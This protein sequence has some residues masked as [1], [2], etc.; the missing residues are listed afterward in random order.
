M[1]I[2]YWNPKSWPLYVV[3]EKF[4]F[5]KASWKCRAPIWQ[6]LLHNSSKYWSIWYVILR[7]SARALKSC[8]KSLNPSRF[9][10]DI[11]QNSFWSYIFWELL[12]TNSLGGQI[13]P[14]ITYISKKLEWKKKCEAD[15]GV[16]SLSVIKNKMHMHKCAYNDL[17]THW[18]LN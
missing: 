9:G 6:V 3:V 16:G 7:G 2:D 8:I 5:P 4:N 10:R 15:Q 12:N 13:W 1:I 17:L 18:N 11:E 14:Q